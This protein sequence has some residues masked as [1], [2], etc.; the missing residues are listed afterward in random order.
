[1]AHASS[2]REVY[3]SVFLVRTSD[4][5]S[6]LFGGVALI[7]LSTTLRSKL[8]FGHQAFSN[9]LGMKRERSTSDGGSIDIMRRQ[10]LLLPS[11]GGYSDADAKVGGSASIMSMAVSD[12]VTDKAASSG[13]KVI[14]DT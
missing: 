12:S 10:S 8:A 5:N 14:R 4:S 2:A 9:K 11:G 3:K 7:I 6:V 13:L 1:M